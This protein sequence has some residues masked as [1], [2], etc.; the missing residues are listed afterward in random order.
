MKPICTLPSIRP[1]SPISFWAYGGLSK[2]QPSSPI[3]I[4]NGRAQFRH[5]KIHVYP[6]IFF[7]IRTVN[8][9]LGS[10]TCRPKNASFPRFKAFLESGKLS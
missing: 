10:F 7:E 9:F 8:G 2:A 1:S 3:R 5:H 6:L 4:G